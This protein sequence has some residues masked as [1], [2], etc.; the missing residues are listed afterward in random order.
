MFLILAPPDNSNDPVVLEAWLFK[1]LL[2][3][4]YP[5]IV[6]LYVATKSLIMC[7]NSCCLCAGSEGIGAPRS[8]TS[9]SVS[10][11]FTLISFAISGKLCLIW[12]NKIFDSLLVKF[13]IPKDP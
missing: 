5:D 13:P 10:L 7:H 11:I 4:Y 8:L 1:V 9:S 6:F 12:V 3:W 2:L